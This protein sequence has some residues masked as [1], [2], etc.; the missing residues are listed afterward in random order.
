MIFACWPIDRKMT[1]RFSE[2]LRFNTSGSL[3]ITLMALE[4]SF[5]L[6]CEC[7]LSSMETS[8]LAYFPLQTLQVFNVTG[9]FELH[10]K[11]TFMCSASCLCFTSMSMQSNNSLPSPFCD[12]KI[13]LIFSFKSSAQVTLKMSLLLSNESMILN[14]Q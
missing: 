13:T 3:T 9:A 11:Q 12:F 8:N 6:K 4:F 1:E 14:H 5:A 7:W 2:L 10:R